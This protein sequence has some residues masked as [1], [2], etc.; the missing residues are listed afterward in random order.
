VPAPFELPPV[1][2]VGPELKNTICLSRGRE[3]FL[4]HHIGDLKNDSVMRSFEHAI[5][6]LQTILEV[7][8][9][10]LAHDMH[11]AYMSTRFALEQNELPTLAVQHHHAHLAACMC[12]H[13]LTE[14]AIGV[15]FDGTGYGTDG[16]IW[17]GELLI[18]DYDGFERAGQ[19]AYFRLPGGDKAV[20]EPY[21]VALALLLQAYGSLDG[22]ELPV[23]ARRDEQ[24]R[25]VLSRMV[26]R[27]V[28]SPVTSSMG[29]L[30][31]GV[32]ALIGVR[33]HIRYEAQ[34][35]IELEQ[36]VEPG[37]W[38]DPLPW[39]L[40]LQDGRLVVDPRPLVR[41]LVDELTSGR[42]SQSELSLRF[43]CTVVDMV[44]AACRALRER[45]GVSTVVLSG[46]V[47][48]NQ[49][50]LSGSY[51]ALLAAG[52]DVRTHRRVPTNDGGVALGQAAIAGWRAR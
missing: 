43:H 46:G 4:S 40:G 38:A 28:H 12:E 14:P 51:D 11:P 6:H 10:V 24:E 48:L 18:G 27:G 32:A 34:A 52:F 15:I 31:D 37:A 3:L 9:Q 41:A 20:K 49:F 23:V 47:F 25:Q 5:E 22:I 50:L 26:E 19:L 45:T 36:L 44:R 7:R 8:P 29:R 30:F 42:A 33:E 1:L 39:E 21:R 2:A 16:A 35:A 13:G 17:G